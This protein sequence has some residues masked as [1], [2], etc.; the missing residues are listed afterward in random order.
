MRVFTFG[1][2]QDHTFPF[3]DFGYRFTGPVKKEIRDH[4]AG[5]PGNDRPGEKGQRKGLRTRNRSRNPRDDQ[6]ISGTAAS[7]PRELDP[8][9]GRMRT[10]GPWSR[11][12]SRRS[13]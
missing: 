6:A 9:L 12:L 11:G 1:G 2:R 4:D 7:L 5:R 3:I 10:S 13:R 8:N